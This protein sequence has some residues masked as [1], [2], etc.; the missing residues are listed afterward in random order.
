M[1]RLISII[2]NIISKQEIKPL[3]RW[4]I[5]YCNKKTNQK[6]DL[7]NEDHC[8]PCGQYAITKLTKPVIDKKITDAQITNINYETYKNL[9]P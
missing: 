1:K 4:N 2:K 7:S 6:V 9:K 3:G 8:G 5:D